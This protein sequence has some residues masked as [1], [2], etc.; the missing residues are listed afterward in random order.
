ME[1]SRQLAAIMFTDIEGYTRLMQQNEEQAIQLRIKHREIF[2]SF[3]KKFGGRILQYFGDGTLS[4]FSSAIDAINCAIEMQLNFRKDPNVPVRI[5]IHTGDI[6][7]SDDEIIGDGVNI[8][9]RIES[10]ALA[11]SILISGKVYDEIKN[12]KSIN[13]N[14]VKSINLKNVSKP[15]DVY[16]ISNEGLIIPSAKDIHSKNDTKE[17]VNQ[18]SKSRSNNKSRNYIISIAAV[19]LIVVLV[20]VFWKF[21][22]GSSSKIDE[23]EKSI[24]VLPFVNMSDDPQQE[25]FSDGISE[26]ILNSLV[27]VT[28]LKVAGRTSSFSFKGKNEDI[29]SIGS[30]LNVKMVLEGSVRK[31]E[32][33]VRVTAQ[34]INVEDGYHLWSETYDRELKHIISVQEEIANQIVEKLKL[35]VENKTVEIEKPSNMEAYELLLK[36]SYLFYRDFED[37]KR[38]MEYFQKAVELDPEYAEA[39]AYIGESYLHFAGF[40]LM[41]TS[42]AYAK[43]RSAA[44]KALSLNKFEARAHKVLAYI[45]LFFDWDWDAT[46]VDYNNAIKYG[47]SDLNEFI[48]Y[49]EI[50]VNNNAD[51]AIKVA[52]ARIQN[53][54]LSIEKY[55]QLGICNHFAERFEEA[56]KAYD[57][58]LELDPNYSSALQWKG[59]ALGYMGEYDEAMSYLKKANEITKGEGLV[60]LDVLALKIQMGKKDEVLPVLE[61]G[62]YIDPMDPARLYLMLGMNDKALDWLEK[63]YNVRSVMMVTLKHLWVWDPLRNEPRFKEIYKKMNF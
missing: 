59:A 43:A 7:L 63:G 27:K 10:F 54:P 26:E 16:A 14:F 23:S 32:N 35:Q 56:I 8:A 53:D 60:Y 20:F 18:K 51:R 4:I 25:Y 28:G 3:T 42:D 9:S 44:K 11:G 30:K 49:Y 46:L 41:P 2:N 1:R 19:F 39:Y 22:N 13:A 38:A 31:A 61:S 58:A 5:G 21:T 34:L 55:W 37:K 12:Q 57:D 36:G 33:Q 6:I 62:E 50:F 40:N 24:A 17:I 45:H 48:L 29:R 52:K 15:I 47:M